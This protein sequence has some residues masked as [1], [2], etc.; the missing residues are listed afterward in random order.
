M[1]ILFVRHGKTEWNN[2]KKM[3]GNVDIPLSNE[4]IEHAKVM[5]EKLQKYQKQ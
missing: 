3:Q 1:E 2:Q 4:G 5:A